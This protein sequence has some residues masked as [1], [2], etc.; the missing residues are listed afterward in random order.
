MNELQ[1]VNRKIMLKRQAV[2][3]INAEIRVL[4]VKK[5]LLQMKADL[6]SQIGKD[7]DRQLSQQID[8]VRFLLEAAR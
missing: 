8:A 5:N 4:R 2:K 1:T 7:F 6:E 3:I